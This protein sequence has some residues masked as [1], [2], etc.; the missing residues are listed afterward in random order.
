VKG[1][2]LIILLRVNSVKQSHEIAGL[3]KSISIS[4]RGTNTPLEQTGLRHGH[5]FELL[6]KS[7]TKDL[8]ILQ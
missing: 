8:T 1:K 6:A 4:L 5:P 7:L 3:G 2:N